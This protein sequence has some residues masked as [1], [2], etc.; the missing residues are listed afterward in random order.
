[1]V[2]NSQAV[3][4]RAESIAAL[5]AMVERA[6]AYVTAMRKDRVDALVLQLHRARIVRRRRITATSALP[7]RIIPR[8]AGRRIA[9][10]RPV[11]PLVVAEA[12]RHMVVAEA[13]AVERTSK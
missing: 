13:A 3:N 1:M 11:I 4:Q 12:A 7:H 2:G 6:P 8:R 5:L 10:H 9:H